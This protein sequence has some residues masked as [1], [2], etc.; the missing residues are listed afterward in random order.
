M[1]QT[2]TASND[3]AVC[4]D[5]MMTELTTA[6]ACLASALLHC[7]IARMLHVFE[8]AIHAHVRPSV[9]LRVALRSML[10]ACVAGCCCDEGQGSSRGQGQPGCCGPWRLATSLTFCQSLAARRAGEAAVSMQVNAV[11]FWTPS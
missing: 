7:C 9:A 4:R 6:P 1:Q 8:W 11:C 3:N 5:I 10:L 2:T